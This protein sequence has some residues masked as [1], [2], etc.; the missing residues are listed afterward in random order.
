MIVPIVAAKT[1]AMI[2]W[3]VGIGWSIIAAPPP[4]IVA[5]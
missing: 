3:P 2:I 1:A 5:R 4:V